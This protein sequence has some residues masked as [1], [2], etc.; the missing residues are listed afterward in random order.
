MVAQTCVDSFNQRRPLLIDGLTQGSE[1]ALPIVCLGIPSSTVLEQ[2]VTLP[3]RMS[4]VLPGIHVSWFHVEQRPIHQGSP[5][6]GILT[7]KIRRSGVD[8]QQRHV[9]R[10]RRGGCHRLA[11]ET[12][13]RL[14]AGLA[15]C[16]S[17]RTVVGNI[18]YLGFDPEHLFSLLQEIPSLGRQKGFAKGDQVHGLQQGSLTTAIG[19]VDEIDERHRCVIDGGETPKTSGTQGREPHR[20]KRTRR[21]RTVPLQPS[22]ACRAAQIASVTLRETSRATAAWA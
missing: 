13:V 12:D 10:Q 9:S 5:I 11:V 8:D 2:F 17:S 21:R 19:P 22:A 7:K 4:I 14:T 15:H 1:H 6:G 20:F 18:L 16:N 3:E